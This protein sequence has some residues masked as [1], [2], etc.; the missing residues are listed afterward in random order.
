MWIPRDLLLLPS[1]TLGLRSGGHRKAVGGLEGGPTLELQDRSWRSWHVVH[2]AT[3]ERSLSTAGRTTPQRERSFLPSSVPPCFASTPSAFTLSR[4]SDPLWFSLDGKWPCSATLKPVI[5]P[6]DVISLS[7]TPY[8]ARSTS[9]LVKHSIKLRTSVVESS[10]A[11]FL[12]SDHPIHILWRTN[13]P[14]DCRRCLTRTLF[15]PCH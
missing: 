6:V 2:Q 13:P 12:P 15:S 4:I 5:D 11:A 1:L 8:S 14:K 3:T 10:P 7:R 9:L